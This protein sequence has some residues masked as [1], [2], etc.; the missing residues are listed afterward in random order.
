MDAME[1]D[2][3][4]D[5]E[6]DLIYLN[7]SDPWPKVRHAKRRLSSDIFLKKYDNVFSGDKKI[8][9]KT[10][11][12]DLFEYSVESLSEYGYGLDEVVLDLHSLNE[13]DNVM[14]EYE[15]R[16]ALLGKPIYR[17]KALKRK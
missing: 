5:H 14:T 16:F 11:N 17:I 1:I 8:I 4:F 15:T 2:Q 7:F 13:R 6:I 10:D 9:M 3:I 12:Q